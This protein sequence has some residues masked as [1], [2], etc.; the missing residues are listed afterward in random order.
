[1]PLLAIMI[2]SVKPGVDF[3]TGN[4]WGIP[5]SFS[6]FEN[7]GKVFFESDMPRYLL[8]SLMI[9]VPTVIRLHD[10]Q[11]DDGLRARHL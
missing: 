11:R 5:S 6:F 8:N 10:P 4:Y 2:F 9:T 3:T 1:M 7:Y